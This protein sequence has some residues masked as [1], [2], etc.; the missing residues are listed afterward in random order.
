VVDKA[1]MA[2]N[3]NSD[4]DAMQ[5]INDNQG[6]G[7]NV[8]N[9]PMDDKSK[10]EEEA[11]QKQVDF[12]NSMSPDQK[13]AFIA[14]Y[15]AGNIK[16]NELPSAVPE[17]SV[18]ETTPAVQIDFDGNKPCEGLKN[19]VLDGSSKGDET[20]AGATEAASNKSPPGERTL[21]SFR[22]RVKFKRGLGSVGACCKKFY[23][24]LDIVQVQHG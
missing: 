24:M 3:T 15:D 6:Q 13:A 17:N 23:K 18:P 22:F 1:T 16:L 12:F 19:F 21:K 20:A 9:T 5:G 2:A 11:R 10:E 4:G 8:P 7:G 14:I